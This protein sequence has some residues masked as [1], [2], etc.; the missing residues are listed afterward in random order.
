MSRKGVFLLL[1]LVI[2]IGGG[3]FAQ[4]RRGARRIDNWISGEIGFFNTG[5]RY[6][7]MLNSQFSIGAEAYWNSFIFFWNDLGII[8]AARFYPNEMFFLELGL[9]YNYHTGEGE[10]KYQGYN[11]L[12]GETGTVTTTAWMSTS[13]VCISPGLGLRIDPGARGGFFVSP[14]LKVPVTIGSQKPV[15]WLFSYDYK[16]EI[17]VGVGIMLYCGLGY[18]W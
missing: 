14:G 11:Y 5:I 12:S 9:G 1:V 6:E 18:A 8:A 4:Q 3:L 17:G 16:S 10:Y 13:G 15:T 2:F 7:R